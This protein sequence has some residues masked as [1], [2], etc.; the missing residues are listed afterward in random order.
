[1]TTT[2]CNHK[3]TS[4]AHDAPEDIYPDS[5]TLDVT[6]TCYL[7]GSKEEVSY[8]IDPNDFDNTFSEENILHEEVLSYEEFCKKHDLEIDV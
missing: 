2:Y 3:F 8:R 6:S 7:C 1:M 5:E 4:D